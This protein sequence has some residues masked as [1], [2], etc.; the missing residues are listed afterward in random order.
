M[1]LNNWKFHKDCFRV[2]QSLEESANE[3]QMP[4]KSSLQKI[5]VL[6]AR[7]ICED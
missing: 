7:Y 5:S 1:M 4:K 3:F 2:A 6:N